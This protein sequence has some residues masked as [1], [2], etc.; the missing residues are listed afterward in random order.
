MSKTEAIL[1]ALRASGAFEAARYLT[2]RKLR[3]LCY[4]GLWLGGAPHYGDCL[5]MDPKKF[6]ERMEW[7]AASRYPVLGLDEA[8]RRLDDGSLPD[9]AVVITIDDGWYST[10]RG[11]VP[12][13]VRLG[14]PA[15][16]YV[17]TYYATRQI[18]VLNVLIQHMLEAAPRTLSSCYELLQSENALP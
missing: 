4:H 10:Y 17:T 13:L 5:Y 9:N 7:L 12:V 8:L 3:I 2:R 14:L 16:V 1:R 11:M 6:E 18:P 15:T